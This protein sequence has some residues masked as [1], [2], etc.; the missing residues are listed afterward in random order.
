MVSRQTGAVKTTSLHSPQLYIE[1][2]MARKKDTFACFIDFKKAFDCVN[3][4][5]L[6]KKLAVRFG[7]SGKFLLALSVVQ[8]MSTTP[9]L[10]GLMSTM[11]LNKD[12]YILSLTFFVMFIDDLV[13]EFKVKQLGVNCQTCIYAIMPLVCR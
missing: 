4:D 1:N 3:R 8:W 9:T 13:A 6:W 5:L 12:N 7:L 11:G 2:R 10:I